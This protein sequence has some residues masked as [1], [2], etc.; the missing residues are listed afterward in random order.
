MKVLVAHASRYGSTRE[1]AETIAQVLRS[2]CVHA[3][4]R[5]A[6]EVEDI[7]GYDGV[8]LG[9]G[10]Y[11]GRWHRN[12]R[13]FA[14]V[15]WRELSTMPVAVFALGPLDDV[16]EHL[17]GS[18]KQFHH[19]LGKLRFTPFATALF[20]GA[21]DPRKLSFPFSHMP[22]ADVRDWDAIRGWAIGIADTFLSAPTRRA[23]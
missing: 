21:V 5:A 15:F 23:A 7:D 19:A 9:G 20:G 16:P 14:R 8:V 3:D 6:G 4:V 10:I 2:R 18:E 12:A 11:V 13:G 1:V 17:A 22:A